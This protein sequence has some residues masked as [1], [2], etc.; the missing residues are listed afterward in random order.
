MWTYD[1][2]DTKITC[3]Y[4]AIP[5]SAEWIFL[6]VALGLEMSSAA[7]DQA[8]SPSKPH[9]ALLSMLC[10]VAAL[11]TTIWELTYKAIKER[12]VLRRSGLLMLPYFYYPPPR[13]TVFGDLYD[14]YGFVG[15]ISQC[16]CSAVQYVY[17]LRHADNP[18]KSSLLPAIFLM[19]LGASRLNRNRRFSSNVDR[20]NILLTRELTPTDPCS[21]I[22]AETYRSPV[23]VLYKP[24]SHPSLTKTPPTS[25]F[26]CQDAWFWDNVEVKI[27]MQIGMSLVHG[28]W[29]TEIHG[30]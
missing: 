28:I 18:I 13:N 23:N 19:C 11:L 17:F 7:F 29:M 10:A 26:R 21:M 16:A 15:G 24:S 30:I 4:E 25:P 5:E 2:Q 8:S 20:N 22:L 9:Y 27:M 12:V 3:W 1:S 6:V 14:I